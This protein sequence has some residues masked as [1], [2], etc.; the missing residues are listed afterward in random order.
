M[1]RK[2]G[3]TVPYEPKGIFIGAPTKHVA[4]PRSTESLVDFAK[5]NL[6]WIKDGSASV[7]RRRTIGEDEDEVMTGISRPG[8]SEVPID[9]ALRDSMIGAGGGASNAQVEGRFPQ[10]T[11]ENGDG[12]GQ[13]GSNIFGSLQAHANH[14][15]VRGERGEGEVIMGDR[16]VEAQNNQQNHLGGV[17]IIFG[18]GTE[19]F[20][21]SGRFGVHGGNTSNT[22]SS[23]NTA[24]FSANNWHPPLSALEENPLA[25]IAAA[26]LGHLPGPSS[27]NAQWSGIP[28]RPQTP[29]HFYTDPHL[30]E[31]NP[32][33]HNYRSPSTSPPPPPRPLP[34]RPRER[35][36]LNYPAA[37]AAAN[38]LPP[39]R[40]AQIGDWVRKT[41]QASRWARNL[42][43][44]RKK[45]RSLALTL[46]PPLERFRTLD[47]E[48]RARDRVGTSSAA[49]WAP[50]RS[51][52]A[53]GAL[54]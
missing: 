38:T 11:N 17:G 54:R 5:R 7:K 45:H 9:P 23:Q 22:F 2:K 48:L 36:S 12:D 53:C 43:G 31:H 27:A 42:S 20:A 16:D 49:R 25:F 14:A 46:R 32:A 47:A 39:E 15:R 3:G 24:S 37:A 10:T 19:H 35:V 28:P 40:D 18:N 29:P 34:R 21:E 4:D 30:L 26:G 8:N 44:S 41:K 13:R 50:K 52:G 6:G 51:S 1:C 33:T